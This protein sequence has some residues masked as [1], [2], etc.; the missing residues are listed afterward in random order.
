MSR[1]LVVDDDPELRKL[2]RDCLSRAGHE[3]E[4]AAGGRSAVDRFQKSPAELLITDLSMP[5]GDGF[6]LVRE[7]RRISSVPI[8]VLTVRGD[9]HEKIRMLDEGADDYVTKPFGVD[10]LLARVRALLRRHASGRGTSPIVTIGDLRVDI[11]TRQVQRGGHEIRLTP[12]EFSLL[13]TF[14]TK[15]GGVWT[16]AQLIAAVWGGAEGVTSDVV[17]VHVGNLRR[18]IERDPNRPRL[19]VTEPW[20]GYRFRLE[21]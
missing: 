8:L 18:K 1:I 3:V 12:T 15:P 6:A 16:H 2:L 14:L 4:T 9:E 20:V 19:L 5:A 10:E 21:D 11:S 17:R 7:L 13:E